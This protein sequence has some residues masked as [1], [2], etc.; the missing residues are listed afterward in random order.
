MSE[1]TS[2]SGTS[3]RSEKQAGYCL[4]QTF[5]GE[6]G[7]SLLHNLSTHC[8]CDPCFTATCPLH[9]IPLLTRSVLPRIWLSPASTCCYSQ[10]PWNQILLINN[11]VRSHTLWNTFS[12]PLLVSTSVDFWLFLQGNT[13]SWSSYNKRWSKIKWISVLISLFKGPILYRF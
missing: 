1:L 9:L 10:L 6:A 8:C 12:L 2:H 7:W 4:P 13:V 11:S 3:R 5:R